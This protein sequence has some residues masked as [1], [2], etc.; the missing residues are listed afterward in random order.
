VSEEQITE[1]TGAVR[2]VAEE[3][4]ASSSFWMDALH[5]ARRAVNV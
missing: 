2:Q 3:V 5:M 4:H 1:F